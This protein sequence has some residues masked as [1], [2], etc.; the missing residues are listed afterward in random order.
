EDWN[1]SPRT[2]VAATWPALFESQVA[3]R[4]DAMAVVFGDRHVTHAALN[5][6]ANRLAHLLIAHGVGPEDAVG[7]A[8][9]R[10][11]ETI[12]AVL[13]TLKAGAAYLPLDVSYP[14]ERLAFMLDDT[15][16]TCILT[17]RHLVERWRD[18]PRCVAMDDPATR[19]ALSAC[20]DH[21]P[22]DRDRRGRLYLHHP[23]Y[24]IYTSGSTGRPK[25]VVTTH[26]GIT[27]L[28]EA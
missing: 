16:P 21:D 26:A 13:G 9:E 2:A 12:V 7:I 5:A 28:A 19:E 23:A 6:R 22:T 20:P 3:R 8:I 25:G 4:P 18:G 17:M 14:A 11:D 15:R 27:A 10:S 1:E 24:I